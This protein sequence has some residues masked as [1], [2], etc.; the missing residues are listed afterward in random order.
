MISTFSRKL[1]KAFTE[2]SI[3]GL[4]ISMERKTAKIVAVKVIDI[5]DEKILKEVN[6]EICNEIKRINNEKK[7]SGEN[8][9][10]IYDS[11][12]Y[13]GRL[14]I[15]LE[16]FEHGSLADLLVKNFDATNKQGLGEELVKIIIKDL[17]FILRKMHKKKKIIKNIKPSNMFITLNGEIKLFDFSFGKILDE[18]IK[19][20]KKCLTGTPLYLAPEAI[21]KGEFTGKSDIWSVGILSLE[22]IN[23]KSP[24]QEKHSPSII[25]EI[26]N[27]KSPEPKSN[28]SKAFKIFTA[29][30]LEKRSEDRHSI[31]QLLKSDFILSC[32][33][34]LI[35]KDFLHYIN[36]KSMAIIKNSID[37]GRRGSG[38][39]AS[40]FFSLDRKLTR[41]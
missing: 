37:L 4:F 17:L 1:V 36:E 7:E 25:F 5:F 11:F 20:N 27:K 8:M 13:D 23:G 15:I 21:S 10:E 35:L 38:K 16:Y 28:C 9:A 19:K 33:S 31:S 32:K 26:V 34:K 24:F 22:L 2:D 39:I 29:N 14:F 30:C 18:S 12:I 3:N 6:K 41:V 40:D